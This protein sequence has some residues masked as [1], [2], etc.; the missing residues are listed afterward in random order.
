[1]RSRPSLSLLVGATL[2]FFSI[3]GAWV[4]DPKASPRPQMR[5]G[6]RVLSADFHVHTTWGDGA[7][8]PFAIARQATR[9][10]LDVVGI[11]EHNRVLPAKLAQAYVALVGGPIVV[12]GEE[13]TRG[14]FHV[15]GLGLHET[16]SPNQPLQ[17]ILED[18]HR[19]GGVA[20]AAHPTK[21]FWP[22]LLPRRQQLDGTEVMHPIAYRAGSPGWKWQDM[23][24]FHRE[25]EPELAAIGSSDYHWGSILGLCR[26]YVFVE[27]EPSEAT[28]IAAIRARRTVTFDLEGQGHGDRDL[29][30]LLRQEPLHEEN[31]DYKYVG[32]GALDKALQWCGIAGALLLLFGAA[33]GNQSRKTFPQPPAADPG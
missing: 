26:T 21:P 15:I 30:A 14:N 10:N 32:K 11:T 24:Q 28:V 9:R 1:M 4:F 17:A 20:I 23:E 2:C 22:S 25:A 5:G 12:S 18:I 16:V 31:A 29:V 6:Y 27:G 3:V 19:Q 13:V 7:L 8:S 33:R